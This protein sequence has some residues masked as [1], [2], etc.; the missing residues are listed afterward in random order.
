[1]SEIKY[2]ES[3][4]RSI[5]LANFEKFD[6]IKKLPPEKIKEIKVVSQVLPFKSNTYCVDRLIDWNNYENDPIFVLTFPNREMLEP[7]DFEA[8]EKLMDSGADAKAIKEKANEIRR[9]LNPHPA[10]QMQHNLPVHEEEKLDGMQHKYRETILF[11]PTQGQTCHAYCTFCFRWAQFVGMD[12]LKFATQESAKL[13]EYLQ[14]HPYTSDVLFTGGDPMI[15]KTRFLKAYFEEVAKADTLRTVRIGTKALAYWPRRWTT[16]DDAQECLDLFKQL[17]DQGKHVSIMAHFNHP[18]ELMTEEVQEAIAAIRSTGAQIRTQSPVMKNINDSTEV[19][20]KMWQRQ[21]ELGLVP[22]YFFVARDTGAQR[23]FEVPLGRAW[24][25]YRNAYNRV[26]GLA[27]TVRGPSMSASPGK[28]QVV[29]VSE[30]K[31]EKV[32]VLNFY[33]GRK[34]EWVGRPF[35]AKYD[36][37]ASWLT[38]LKPAF[39]EK[40]FFYEKELAALYDKDAGWEPNSQAI[41]D[42][43]VVSIA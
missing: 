22:Y 19:W 5:T 38:D 36:A 31:G 1:M 9:T 43:S 20:A 41:P 4:Y 6:Q 2:T 16:D 30:I 11:F 42:T 29:G 21:V 24:D 33:Q 39:G 27:R 12:D 10:G 37:K 25:I 15:M 35:F 32:F 17:A 3:Q 8:M 28:V 34:A 13:R 26:S 18:N 7:A 23:Y 14:Q 40:E